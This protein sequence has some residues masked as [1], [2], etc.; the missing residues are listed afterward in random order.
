MPPLPEPRASGFD[1]SV[2]FVSVAGNMATSPFFRWPGIP[3]AVKS[4]GPGERPRTEDS[5]TRRDHFVHFWIHVTQSFIRNRCLIR[6][7]AL[8]FST[9]LAFIPML[10]VAISVTNSLLKS[11]GEDQI[12]A[13]INHFI[14]QLVPPAMV[15]AHRPDAAATPPAVVSLNPAALP[16]TALPTGLPTN[17]VGTTGAG[18][19]A[20]TNGLAALPAD[21][22]DARV[23]TAQK[24]AARRIHDFV[25]NT[26]S[27]TLGII[28]MLGLIAVAIFML[29]GIEDT[30]NDIWGV[31]RGRN[32][33]WRIVLYWAV[34]TLG[35]VALIG[36][37]SLAASSP[38]TTLWQSFSQSPLTG[39]P[40]FKLLSVPAL[41][42]VFALI[43]LAV[44]NTRVRFGPALAGGMVAGSL[45]QL[46]NYLGYLYVS[47]V[48]TN[49]EIYGSL[50]LLPV[51]MAGLYGSWV[52]LLLGVQVSCACQNRK[53]YMQDQ[54]AETVNQRGREFIALR[55]MT[56]L[57]RRYQTGQPAA[58]LPQIAAELGVSTRLAREILQTL[59]AARLVTEVAGAEAAYVPA[60]SLET[61][62]AHQVLQAVRS[63]NPA[64]TGTGTEPVRDEIYGEFARIEE[65]ER[66]A[67]ATVS[68]QALVERAHA[69]IELPAAPRLEAGLSWAEATAPAPI[70]APTVAV[71]EPE[72]VVVT[73]HPP[74][75]PP[76]KFAAPGENPGFPR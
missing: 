50:G 58:S 76:R 45:W 57:G 68:L 26:R 21:G 11:E 16:P 29:A 38:L 37:S 10:A 6:A 8:A 18:A 52:I 3:G 51:F 12:Y 72:A 62:N 65:A 13:A 44:P 64:E 22:G 27:G 48:I 7:S 25:Q 59:L 60:R 39:Q 53:A 71:P 14:A 34:I 33:L 19:V 43:Y 42:L 2:R 4:G 47:R 24:E 35:P 61:I 28:G 9:L 49:S 31:G 66:V 41:W 20:G 32:W 23:I 5:L 74:T 46:N 17:A 70:P 55:L 56:G 69:R 67:A 63:V 73:D 54:F 40:G 75:R 1:F 36:A 15:G 30:F